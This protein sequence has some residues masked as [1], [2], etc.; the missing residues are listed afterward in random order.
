MELETMFVDQKW[1]ILEILAH[2]E[3]SPLEISEKTNTTISNISQQLKLLELSGFVTK[4]RISNRDRGKPRMIYQLANNYS[5]LISIMNDFTK[6]KLLRLTPHNRLILKIWFLEDTE[7]HYYMEKV[8]WTIEKH[9]KE[10]SL[11]A[12]D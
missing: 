11:I 3:L 2:E 8:Y 10:I 9:L 7:L 4:K 1:K 6:K 12:I 5:Y